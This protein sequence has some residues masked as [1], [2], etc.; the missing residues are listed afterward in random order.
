M[1]R[2]QSVCPALYLSAPDSSCM[3]QCSRTLP[4][5]C[6]EATA[7]PGKKVLTGVCFACGVATHMVS[8]PRVCMQK[9]LTAA[10]VS[11]TIGCSGMERLPHQRRTPTPICRFAARWLIAGKGIAPVLCHTTW[12]KRTP[13][14]LTTMPAA[15]KR[16]KRKCSKPSTIYWPH[17]HRRQSLL[18]RWP[19]PPFS[20]LFSVGQTRVVVAA[21]VVAPA[22]T[23]MPP[24]VLV[25]R[26]TVVPR[27][28]L[29][30]WSVGHSGHRRRRS[31]IDTRPPLTPCNTRV[32]AANM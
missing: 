27:P 20:L 6:C 30:L 10:V 14:C 25:H 23:P 21:V 24:P 7:G 29:L 31:S 11:H 2:E 12:H 8:V 5:I 28:L 16:R 26:P 9:K 17:S 32:G 18:R 4:G 19:C 13:V 1:L 22:P 15:A 3:L